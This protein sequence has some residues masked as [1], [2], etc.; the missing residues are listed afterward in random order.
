M[1]ASPGPSSVR[2]NLGLQVNQHT[3]CHCSIKASASSDCFLL[4]TSMRSVI[5]RTLCNSLPGTRR[6]YHA[7]V[8]PSLISP[9]SPE[10]IAKSEA[11]DS[12]V[13]EVETK[14][15]EARQGGGPKATDRMRKQG[16]KLP[17]ERYV[18]LVLSIH[19]YWTRN[20]KTVFVIMNLLMRHQDLVACG[21]SYAFS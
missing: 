6:A 5:H 15:A 20:R 7:S 21:P 13:H 9:S 8:L 12:L 3:N 19:A 10:F 16:K 2:T 1:T 17:R 4:P 18:T 14:M 11:M